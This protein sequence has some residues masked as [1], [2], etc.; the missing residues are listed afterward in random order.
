VR[1]Q[2]RHRYFQLASPEVARVIE[3][4]SVVAATGPRR[5]RPAS[6]KDEALRTAR[7]CYDHM[8]G[9]LGVLTQKY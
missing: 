5:H 2:G 8:A 3:A 7:T 6:L 9:R 4:L 1:K